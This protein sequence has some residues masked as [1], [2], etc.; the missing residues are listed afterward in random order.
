MNLDLIVLKME[1]WDRWLAKRDLDSESKRELKKLKRESE[2]EIIEV[3]E[4][5]QALGERILS[6][7]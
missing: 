5:I 1:N 4:I 2:Q 3:D 6:G 7:E